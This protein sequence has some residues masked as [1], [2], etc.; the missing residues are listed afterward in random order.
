VAL[1]KYL[2]TRYVDSFLGGAV[3]FQPL[4]Y[5]QR[6]E[7]DRAIG[8]P[9][10]AMLLF[11]PKAGLAVNNLTTGQRFQLPATFVS[12]VI[13]NDVWVFCVSQR[14]DWTLAAQFDADA[15]VEITDVRRFVLKLQRAVKAQLA[16]SVLL[17]RPVRYYE[18]EDP[19]DVNW[20]L[21][22]QIIYSKRVGYSEQSEYRFA[23]ANRRVLKVG[24]AVQR[25]Q[26][27]DVT[28]VVQAVVPEASV[29]EVGDLSKIARLH[30]GAAV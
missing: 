19:A 28:P 8:D 27:G 5:Y 16:S 6:W 2:P 17:N 21:P 18:T 25:L 26:F 30:S 1:F 15:C 14:F 29:L 22:D 9:N 10:E 20:A 7:R 4:S 13:A 12:E 23:F 11:R 3:R 24:N